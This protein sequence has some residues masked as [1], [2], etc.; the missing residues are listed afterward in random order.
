VAY[1]ERSCHAVNGR[2]SG[3]LAEMCLVDYGRAKRR[4]P[5]FGEATGDIRFSVGIESEARYSY[6]SSRTATPILL[7]VPVEELAR[8]IGTDTRSTRPRQRTGI[9]SP[10]VISE[11]IRKVTSISAPSFRSRS[12]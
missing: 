3:D 10:S 5:T 11:G 8:G 6:P 4:S 1:L 12:V 9:A 2:P 7:S